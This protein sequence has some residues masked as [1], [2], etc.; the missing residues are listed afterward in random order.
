MES[1][2]GDTMIVHPHLSK[3]LVLALLYLQQQIL[4]VDLLW[5]VLLLK[6]VNKMPIVVMFLKNVALL[7]VMELDVLKQ[8]YKHV[9]L[10]VIGLCNV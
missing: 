1:V 5:I 9:W 2:P 4:L 7:D 10:L 6:P 8:L 3:M